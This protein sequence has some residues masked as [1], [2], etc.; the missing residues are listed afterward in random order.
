MHEYKNNQE[1]MQAVVD[2]ITPRI[3]AEKYQVLLAELRRLGRVLIA[4]SG[5]VD[6][7]FLLSAAQE[8]LGAN[9][10]AITARSGVVPK[11]DVA[12]G[13][14]FCARRG[15]EHLYFDFDELQVP[16]F[17]ENPPDRCYICKKTLFT[18]FKRIAAERGAV[19][20]EGSNM[21]DLGDYRPGLRALAELEVH[22]PLRVA[23]LGKAEIRYLSRQLGLPTWKKPSFACLASRFVYGEHITAA[24]LA[25]V[26]QAEQI[27]LDNGFSQ[28]RV[29]VHGD[30]ARIEVLPEQLPL[31]AQEPLREQIYSKLKGLG[32]MYVTLDLQGYR[33]GSMNESL[34]STTDARK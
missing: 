11:R 4:F 23:K 6:S 12:E 28:F 29:R 30:L 27:L 10:L 32:F 3:A 13:S 34:R 15:I 33:T 25:A 9:T 2:G 24:K 16:G 14:D 8:A 17:A 20:C 21:D 1:R 7:S 22:S 5:G 18:N 26:D 31:L 19:L